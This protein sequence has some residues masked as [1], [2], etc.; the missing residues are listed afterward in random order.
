MKRGDYVRVSGIEYG[1][2]DG[3]IG[4][5]YGDVA[6]VKGKPA[7]AVDMGDSRE[8]STVI[9][10]LET[11]LTVVDNPKSRKLPRKDKEARA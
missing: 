2:Y 7:W 3:E 8:N 1:S 6:P 4:R 9:A 10:A 5:I 11:H